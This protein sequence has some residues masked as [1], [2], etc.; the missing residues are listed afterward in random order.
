MI[1]RRK[2]MQTLSLSSAMILTKNINADFLTDNLDAWFMPDEAKKHKSTW[3]EFGA[4]KRIWGNKLFA[5]V[6]R[7][8]ATIA[9]TIAQYEPVNMLVREKDYNI[10]SNLLGSSVN[11][12]LS[13]LDD[14]WIRDTGAVFV[15]NAKGQ[16]AAINFNFNGWGEKQVFQNDAKVAAFMSKFAKVK[17][18]NTPLILEGG[19][20]EVDGLKT[21][22]I[23][24]SCVLNANRNLGMSKTEVEIKLKK[25]LGLE[26][27]IWLPGVKG[28]DITDGHTDFY[29]RFAAPDVVV[30]G[31]ETDSQFFDYAVT[32]Q[33]LEILKNT[34]NAQGTKVNVV[35]IPSP[36]S[37]R[38][39]YE[40]NDFA[41]GYIN[42][43]LC[44][45]ALIM[46]EFGD[47]K[48][49]LFAKQTLQSLFPNREIVQINI[50]G[51]AAGG[52]GIHCTTQQEPF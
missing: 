48:A 30:A 34:T 39:T 16:K 12:I 26:K 11:L 4:S 19:A 28:K 23:T 22:I 17:T 51:I 13:P 15:T 3:M 40:T 2:F 43:Y 50:D 18:I 47:K 33:H 32:K 9:Q 42:Y 24:E 52:G 49:D 1:S 27:I 37:I 29:A 20:I 5:E 41:A 21:A 10:A 7:N 14:L 31:L 35:V 46:P 45:N 6:Q 36:K 44:N 8:L 38:K 25:L